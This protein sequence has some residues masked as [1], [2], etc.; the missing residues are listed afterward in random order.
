MVRE[1][2]RLGGLLK[3]L[4]QHSSGRRPTLDQI[5]EVASKDN[6]K[7]VAVAGGKGK[8]HILRYLISSKDRV[9]THLVTDSDTAQWLADVGP[10]PS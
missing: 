10:Y 7:V 8:R 9:I 5:A 4:N 6:G 2:R 1:L 3:S